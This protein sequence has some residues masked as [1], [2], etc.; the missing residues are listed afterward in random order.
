MS[1]KSPVK[2]AIIG[3]GDEGCRAMIRWPTASISTSSAS[4]TSARRS[5]ACRRGSRITRT[6]R[7]LTSR[8]SSTT[9]RKKML[10]GPESR[11]DRHRAAAVAAR[12]GCHR[13][14]EARQA[15]LHREADGA[16]RLGVQ[17]NVPG[18]PRHQ[19]PVTIG[20]RRHY[21]AYYDNANFLVKNGV[22]GEIRHIRALWH[23]NN[24]TPMVARRQQQQPHLRPQDRPAP[25]SVLD[26]QGKVV[27][28][29][30]WKRAFTRT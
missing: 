8:S 29:D 7:P 24:A 26:E 1:G 6:T 25:E 13:G 2:A 23:R 4:A 14:D 16:F 20:H 30:S 28:R 10:D 17:G 12:T 19:S 3:T 27:Y 15:C 18:R 22:L 9:Q 21:S 5:K 11:D